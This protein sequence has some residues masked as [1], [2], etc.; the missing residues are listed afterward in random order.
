M[1]RMP[2]LKLEKRLVFSVSQLANSSSTSLNMVQE[3]DGALQTFHSIVAQCDHLFSASMTVY[4]NET[5]IKGHI[6]SLATVKFL[7]KGK[8]SRVTYK[9][10]V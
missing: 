6:G 1:V 10:L 4:R 2:K 3:V 5:Y 8:D 9:N 7:N